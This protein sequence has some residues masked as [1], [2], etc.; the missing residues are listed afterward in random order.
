MGKFLILFNIKD[1]NIF[2]HLKYFNICRRNINR[3][4]EPFAG[5]AAISIA[6]AYE[7]RTNSSF[8]INDV[9]HRIPYEI[10]GEHDEKDME[11]FML[12]SPSAN[13][14]K[15]WTCEHCEN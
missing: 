14:A 13:R 8:F 7:K 6:T 1:L 10:G 2:W 15:S 5:M 9:N 11:C 3:L 4:I 12:L